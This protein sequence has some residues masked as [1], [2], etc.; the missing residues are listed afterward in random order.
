M[1]EFDALKEFAGLDWLDAWCVAVAEN[2]GTKT[3]IIS[4]GLHFFQ[5]RELPFPAA[6]RE[7]NKLKKQSGAYICDDL[8]DVFFSRFFIDCVSRDRHGRTAPDE[9]YQAYLAWHKG[10]PGA[11]LWPR[12][13]LAVML[14]NWDE[15][16]I[17]DRTGT[18]WIGLKVKAAEGGTP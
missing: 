17:T 7:I 18:W 16:M 14:Y 10:V 2:G 5:I 13:K 3:A 15:E 6:T 8:D 4:S 1:S 12:E 11:P 9:L